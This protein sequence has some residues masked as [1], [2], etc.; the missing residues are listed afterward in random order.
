M[1]NAFTTQPKLVTTCAAHIKVLKRDTGMG[2]ALRL[3]IRHLTRIVLRL[4][5]NFITMVPLP[6][7]FMRQSVLFIGYLE[8]GLG[9]GESLRGLVRS[10]A[11]T[12]LPFALYPYSF[13]VETRLIGAFMKGRYDLQHSH[14]VNVIEMAPDQ[15]PAMFH[16]IGRWKTGYS[17]NILRTYWELPLAHPSWIY[18]LKG[19][20]EIWVPNEFVCR[21]FKG[22]FGGPIVM[23]PPCVSIEAERSFERSHFGMDNGRFYFL[24]SFDYFSH[25]SRKNPL[26]VIRA[27]QAAFPNVV[28]EVGLVIKST[29]AIDQYLDVKFAIVEAARYD[30]RIIVID[31][32][33][34]RDEMLSLIRQ[35]NCYVSLHRSEGFG[36]GMAEAL[37]FGKPLIG[38]DFSGSA[39]FL[40]DRTG[41]PIPV[42]IRPVQAGE[43]FFS[44]GQ[45]WAEPDEAAAAEA[46]CRVFD[47]EQERQRRAEAGKAFVEAQY[48]KENVG[49]IATQR[50]KDILARR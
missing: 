45:N 4:F 17:Y 37:A 11:T 49:R 2:A 5:E 41:F 35:S 44:E 48:G 12:E 19:I 32:S 43:Y 7:L 46:M 31:C 24:F 27:F 29:G 1:R 20:H 26:G 22:V 34:S 38:T 21:A 30:K 3:G 40:S 14:K 23:V 15:V 16:K 9:L 18:M 6:K 42:T 8:A 33:F 28:E 25:P 13:G 47:D 36:M 10:V 50:L 39:D